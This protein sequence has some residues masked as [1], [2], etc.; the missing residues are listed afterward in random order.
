MT[1]TKKEWKFDTVDEKSWNK[2]WTQIDYPNLTQSWEYGEAK[3][4]DGWKPFRF[5]L[6]DSEGL[7][8]GLMQV[9][10]KSL[11][12][13]GGVARINRGP[14][15]LTSTPQSSV[16]A[17]C[18][19]NT[20]L[21][22][23]KLALR[24]RWWYTFYSPDLSEN[25]E[26]RDALIS[27]R[28]NHLTKKSAQGSI[29]LSLKPAVEELLKGQKGKW[30]NLLRKAE[31]MELI[32]EDVNDAVM[33][34]EIVDT[35]K[36][37]QEERGFVGVP[38]PLLKALIAQNQGE[39]WKVRILRTFT[40]DNNQS[41]GFVI[42]VEHGNCATYLVGWTCDMGRKQQANYL[43]LWK[44]IQA[45]KESGLEWFDM[46][47]VTENTPKG[48]AHFKQGVGGEQF[49]LVGEFGGLPL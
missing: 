15:M 47:G 33:V 12:I 18:V 38:I 1:K 10:E 21:A 30:R 16:T 45:A 9:L 27:S 36:Q 48:I 28:Y 14:M 37:F 49:V 31:K 17:N 29:K 24:K 7:D 44:A 3:R 19:V 11:P 13:L 42:V 6:R 40:E 39:N 20:S 8:I 32:V 35:Y 2:L 25:Q 23:K 5:V 26:Y 46:G 41:T 43:L 4:A 22:I 34:A